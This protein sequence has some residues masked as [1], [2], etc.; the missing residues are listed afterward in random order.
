MAGSAAAGCDQSSCQLGRC[1]HGDARGGEDHHSLSLVE[2]PKESR[3]EL[4]ELQPNAKACIREEVS[5]ET[6]RAFARRFLVEELSNSHDWRGWSP[7]GEMK[8][9]RCLGFVS[10]M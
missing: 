1:P 10:T 9:D 5:Q 3:R 7:R 2:R 8:M 6:T 4:L